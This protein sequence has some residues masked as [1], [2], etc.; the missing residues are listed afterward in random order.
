MQLDL[1]IVAERIR[2]EIQV[3]DV[4][5]YAI[6]GMLDRW[7]AARQTRDALMALHQE[8]KTLSLRPGWPYHEPSD[9]ESIRR[10]RPAPIELPRFYLAES[11]IHSKI[12]GA[13]LGAPSGAVYH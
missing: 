1:A 9:L 7:D 4:Q 6:E 11:E 2:Q 10:A 8:L 5:G 13:W 12:R 3:R